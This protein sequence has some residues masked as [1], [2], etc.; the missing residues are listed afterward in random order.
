MG[1]QRE[2]ERE[3]RRR[4][5]AWAERRARAP[6]SVETKKDKKEFERQSTPPVCSAQKDRAAFFLCTTLQ[7]GEFTPHRAREGGTRRGA[8]CRDA[9]RGCV[10]LPLFPGRLASRSRLREKKEGPIPLSP[11]S[12][13]AL[14]AASPILTEGSDIPATL[15]TSADRKG[16]NEA[17]KRSTEGRSLR[18]EHLEK[19][20][21]PLSL[22]FLDSP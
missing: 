15:S 18:R 11:A 6:S 14:F 9:A 1:V 17:A 19:L 12:S 8:W 3:G 10:S 5:Q 4:G 21:L 16:G 2:G 22:F 13:A 7:N 20:P